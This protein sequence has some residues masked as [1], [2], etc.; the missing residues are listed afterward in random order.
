VIYTV[1][2]GYLQISLKRI[3]IKL[4]VT[5]INRIS[6]T[7]NRHRGTSCQQQAVEE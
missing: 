3:A 7:V 1:N 2:D 5:T 4:E 6:G